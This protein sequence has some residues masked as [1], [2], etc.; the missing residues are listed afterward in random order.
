VSRSRYRPGEVLVLREPAI[1]ANGAERKQDA[2]REQEHDRRH[3]G[4]NPGR[5]RDEMHGAS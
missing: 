5:V 1:L 3:A 2:H 4:P